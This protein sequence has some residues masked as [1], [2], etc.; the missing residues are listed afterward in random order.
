MAEV[1]SLIGG[2]FQSLYKSTL[3]LYYRQE[4]KYLLENLQKTVDERMRIPAIR[5]IQIT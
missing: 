3:F 1:M 2:V 5:F 4:I